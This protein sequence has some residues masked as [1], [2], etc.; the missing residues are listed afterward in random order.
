MKIKEKLLERLSN[1]QSLSSSNKHKV[2]CIIVDKE[3]NIVSEGYNKSLLNSNAAVEN[4]KNETF[5]YVVHAEENAIFDVRYYADWD[6]AKIFITDFPCATCARLI[7]QT[8]IKEIYITKDYSKSHK[9]EFFEKNTDNVSMFE[10]LKSFDVKLYLQNSDIND[11]FELIISEEQVRFK[12]FNFIIHSKDYNGMLSKYIAQ[13]YSGIKNS[14]TFWL[15][16]KKIKELELNK[17]RGFIEE[18]KGT[19]SDIKCNL[20]LFG[21]TS[22]IEQL[23]KLLKVYQDILNVYVYDN[24]L[25]LLECLN[26][27]NLHP[28]KGGQACQLLYD[29]YVEE[30]DDE[31]D[32]LSLITERISK[33]VDYTETTVFSSDD[34]EKEMVLGFNLYLDSFVSNNYNYFESTISGMLAPCSTHNKVVWD[35]SRA[36]YN[37]KNKKVSEL[38]IDDN[39]SLIDSSINDRRVDALIQG[40]YPTLYHLD[41]LINLFGNS[42]IRCSGIKLN[43]HDESI[44]VKIHS[45]TTSEWMKESN[46]AIFLAYR[47][48]NEIKGVEFIENDNNYNNCSLRVPLDKLSELIQFYKNF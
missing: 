26:S 23:D 13:Y 29:K 45:I 24:C 20:Y 17:I 44:T 19:N 31:Y 46:R 36:L 2:G 11:E 30:K 32:I 8:G 5:G 43:I 38:F 34:E 39:L 48:Q 16:L 3:F 22:D 10:V 25:E 1:V 4:E 37:Y 27:P 7:L 40:E 12:V 14:K 42:D 6:S 21:C 28:T 15:A 9:N 33:Y 47:I 18:S 35:E 41:H